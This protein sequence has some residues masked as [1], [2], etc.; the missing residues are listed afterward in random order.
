METVKSADGTVIAYDWAGNGP[1]LIVSLGAFCT[2]RTFV[3]PGD[4]TQHFTVSPTTAAAGV[5][6]ATPSRCR[7]GRS[8][9]AA[10]E[11]GPEWGGRRVLDG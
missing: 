10:G 9:P 8:H 3:A 4:L 7:P 1:A 11:L 6:A 2:R 5:T